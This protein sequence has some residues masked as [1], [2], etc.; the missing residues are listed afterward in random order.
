MVI[1]PFEQLEKIDV[2]AQAVDV[3]DGGIGISTNRALAPGFVVIRSGAAEHKNG[4]LLWSKELQDKTFRAGIQYIPLQWKQDSQSG[5]KSPISV[6]PETERK[7]RLATAVFMYTT[8]GIMVTDADG[9]VQSVNDAFVKITGYSADDVVGKPPLLYTSEVQNDAF[10]AEMQKV[11]REQ[12]MW[13][14][15]YWSRRK[16]G[17]VYPQ[18][19]T[20]NAIRNDR[21]E[22][23]QYCSIFSD[24]TEHYQEEEK[25]RL[26]SSTDGLTGLTNRRVFDEALDTEWRRA[27]RLG[28]TLTVIMA[29]IDNFKKYNDTYGHVEGDECLKKVAQTLKSSLH[30]AGDQAA[31]F[32]GEEFTLLLPMA[33]EAQAA[34]IADDMRKRIEALKIP[35]KL[36]GPSGV[37]TISMGVASLVPVGELAPKDL[38]TMADRALYRAKE[39]GRNRVSCASELKAAT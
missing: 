31:R 25:L 15:I 12:G 10:H 16:S 30:R 4:V 8:R 7:H 17:E 22:I 36:N 13:T 5:A 33:K 20:I 18:E 28:Y 39:L 11:L 38:L 37:V 3:G 9:I 32:G 6:D 2:T 26:L 35:H 34:K 24:I 14:G 19:I 27:R 1:I 21:G 23:V 29:D